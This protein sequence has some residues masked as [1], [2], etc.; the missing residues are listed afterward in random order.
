M[1]QPEALLPAPF[2]STVPYRAYLYNMGVLT[3]HRRKGVA[4]ALVQACMR[5]GAWQTGLM[6]SAFLTLEFGAEKGLSSG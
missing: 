6:G 3:G 2:P 5:T 1:M 4:K